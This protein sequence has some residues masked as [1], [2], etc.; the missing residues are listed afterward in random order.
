MVNLTLFVLHARLE[1][2]GSRAVEGA[3]IL[4]ANSLSVA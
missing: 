2:A 3:N 1:Q 4:L